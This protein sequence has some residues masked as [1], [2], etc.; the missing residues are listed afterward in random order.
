MSPN[1]KQVLRALYLR[2]DWAESWFLTEHGT[3]LVQDGLAESKPGS[4]S[5]VLALRITA[6]GR[7]HWEAQDDTKRGC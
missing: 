7:R 3:R 6:A 1:E 4:T 5:D 2:N